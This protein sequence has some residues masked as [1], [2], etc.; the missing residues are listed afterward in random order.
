M[1]ANFI[2][3]YCLKRHHSWNKVIFLPLARSVM[4]RVF[5]LDEEKAGK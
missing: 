3:I 1:V 4:V 2:R 5:I